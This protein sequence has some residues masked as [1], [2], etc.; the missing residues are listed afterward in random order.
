MT[1]RK[2]RKPSFLDLEAPPPDLRD[3]SPCCHP[4]CLPVN[5]QRRAK[6]AL[7]WSGPGVSAQVASLQSPILCPG[8][9]SVG[10]LDCSAK[11][12]VVADREK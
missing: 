8:C 10:E 6:P 12:V 2:I 3:L 5:R 11:L 7:P 4:R 9:T 1:A